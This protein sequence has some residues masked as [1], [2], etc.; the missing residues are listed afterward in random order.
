MPIDGA[1]RPILRV[2]RVAIQ[3]N[4][5]YMRSL[6]ESKVQH[7]AVLKSN[8][9]G[10]GL[11]P[12]AEALIE[13]G[14]STFFVAGLDEAVALRVAFPKVTIAALA[15]YSDRCGVAYERHDIL[16]VMN[17]PGELAYLRRITEPPRYILNIDTGLTRLG[18]AP[19]DVTRLYLESGF[20]QLAPIGIMSHLACSAQPNNPM[21]ELQRSRFSHLYHLLLP[22]WGS[23]VAS[24]GVWLGQPYHFDLTR[25]GSAL[26]GLNDPRIR[27]S[28]LAQVLR[29]SAAVVEV[30]ELCAGGAVGYAA[31]F[32]SRRRSRIAVV[33]MGY[34]HGLP[35]A[36]GNKIVAHI[37]EF[38]APVIGRP[39]MEYLTLDITD[40]PEQLCHRDSWVDFLDDRLTIDD[41]ADATGAVA[42]EI[43]LRLGSSCFRE[44][45]ATTPIGISEFRAAS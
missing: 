45:S 34:V 20:D 23:L 7:A 27:P 35:W 31:T 12:I 36:S 42:Q 26:F 8:A 21:N 44:Y 39:S 15:G 5:R 38:T 3:K 13:V 24:S 33:G 10:L 4:Y 43:V 29:L 41:M 25:L 18:L 2:D 28:P 16:P 37:G 32:R 11:K 30:R 14:C 9:Y 22:A 1:T 40:V 19:R 17:N 6:T